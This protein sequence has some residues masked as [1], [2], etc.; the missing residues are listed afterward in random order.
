MI[1]TD[2]QKQTVST[3]VAAGDNLSVIQKKLTEH[4]KI[5]LTYMDVRF[6]VDDLG[7]ELKNAAPKVDTSDVSKSPPPQS[8]QALTRRGNS[9]TSFSTR[10]ACGSS[11]EAR[12]SPGGSGWHSSPPGSSGPSP[13]F[14]A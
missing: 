7:L 13:R 2:E 9:P 11:P 6:L 4:F 3:W 1:L 12:P 8:Q 10:T 5:S 14:A